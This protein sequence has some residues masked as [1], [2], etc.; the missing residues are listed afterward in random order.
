MYKVYKLTDVN[1]QIYFG[2]TI[3]SLDERLKGHL[4]KSNTTASRKMI[5]ELKIE[6]LEE[7]ETNKEARQAETRLIKQNKDCINK[8]H[9]LEHFFYVKKLKF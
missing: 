4:S 3:R 5:G 8:F 6:C 2:I 1:N 9:S 7:Y